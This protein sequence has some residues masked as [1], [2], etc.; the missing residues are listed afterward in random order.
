MYRRLSTQTEKHHGVREEVVKMVQKFGTIESSW[1]PA[2]AGMRAS[3][4]QHRIERA[5]GATGGH[6]ARGNR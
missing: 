1:Q 4:V 6:G 2:V 5:R 3:A